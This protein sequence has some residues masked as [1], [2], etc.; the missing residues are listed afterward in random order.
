MIH[1][2]LFRPGQKFRFHEIGKSRAR[3]WSYDACPVFREFCLPYCFGAKRS[4]FIVEAGAFTVS[5]AM[6]P[7]IKP[8]DLTSL[9][10]AHFCLLSFESET[11][12]LQPSR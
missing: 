8:I 4:S 1:V 5:P 6:E 12:T 11:E 10:D 7:E 3:P 2:L 9:I